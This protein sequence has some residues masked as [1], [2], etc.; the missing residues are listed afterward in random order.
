MQRKGLPSIALMRFERWS[1]ASQALEA[2][3]RVARRH[4]AAAALASGLIPSL[5]AEIDAAYEDVERVGNW[6]S[7]A[8]AEFLEAHYLDGKTWL[9]VASEAGGG[10]TI[11]TAKKEAMAALKWLDGV[12]GDVLKGEQTAIDLSAAAKR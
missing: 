5:E 12:H 10:W 9:D 3:K 1:K 6:R 2:A 7:A 8:A 11:D 4:D